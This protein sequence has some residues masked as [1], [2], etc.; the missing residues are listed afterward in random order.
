MTDPIVPNYSPSR[1]SKDDS[2]LL[3]IDHRSGVMQLV[4]DYPWPREFGERS[5]GSSAIV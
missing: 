3:M 1:F 2:A 4:H 5:M